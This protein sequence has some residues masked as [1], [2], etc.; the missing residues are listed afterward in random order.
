[1]ALALIDVEYRMLVKIGDDQFGNRPDDL[2]AHLRRELM[3]VRALV[4]RRG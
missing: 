2:L 1:L 3:V 4:T